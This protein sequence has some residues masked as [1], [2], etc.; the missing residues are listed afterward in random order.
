MLYKICI[1]LLTRTPNKYMLKQ[2]HINQMKPSVSMNIQ[3][4]RKD[5]PYKHGF[6]HKYET[7]TEGEVMQELKEWSHSATFY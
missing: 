1:T 6:I 3:I 7:A 2:S 4:L 5:Y